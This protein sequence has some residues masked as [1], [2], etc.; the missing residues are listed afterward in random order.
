METE[1]GV[2]FHTGKG[3]IKNSESRE[4]KLKLRVQRR[5]EDLAESGEGGVRR[6][7]FQSGPPT[8]WLWN[9]PDPQCPYL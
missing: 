7:Q 1:R 9:R 5:P 2:K 4:K 3:V 6:S 8:Y